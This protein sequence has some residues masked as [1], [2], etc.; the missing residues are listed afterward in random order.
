MGKGG[1]ELLQGQAGTQSHMW[2]MVCV[3]V[4]SCGCLWTRGQETMHA[5]A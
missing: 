3:Y 1:E 4:H 2:G 5:Q